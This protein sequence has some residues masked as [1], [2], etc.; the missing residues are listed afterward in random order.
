MVNRT[1]LNAGFMNQTGP[2]LIS[3]QSKLKYHLTCNSSSSSYMA[4]CKGKSNPAI[5]E[6]GASTTQTKI[7]RQRLGLY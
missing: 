3:C 1:L 5:S 2:G 7:I 4:V 6:T